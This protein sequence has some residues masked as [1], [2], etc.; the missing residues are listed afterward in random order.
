MEKPKNS[1]TPQ[2]RLQSR[3]PQQKVFIA[4]GILTLF[5]FIFFVTAYISF[6]LFLIVA[7]GPNEALK[8]GQL[9][10]RGTILSKDEEKVVLK[11][12][13]C[14]FVDCHVLIS[15]TTLLK[16]STADAPFQAGDIVIAQLDRQESLA[17]P[18]ESSTRPG[19][20]VSQ[21]FSIKKMEKNHFDPLTIDN[22][23]IAYVIVLA[24]SLSSAGFFSYKL[25]S[26]IS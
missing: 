23:S 3:T 9:Y 4:L 26:S 2:R 17:T 13:N 1:S 21:I 14:S 20:N 24:V 6:F 7:P 18:Y 11:K 25:Y 15:E 16:R 8:M 10:I 22:D 5:G 12:M 19:M